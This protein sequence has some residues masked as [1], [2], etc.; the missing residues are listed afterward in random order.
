MIKDWNGEIVSNDTHG[1]KE[2]VLLGSLCFARLA[3]MVF[4]T[5]FK[6]QN[7]KVAEEGVI[8]FPAL[9]IL[10]TMNFLVLQYS[11]KHTSNIV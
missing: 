10:Y 2:I 1:Y 8:L 6:D 9:S 11:E 5:K 4:M 3:M 7:R